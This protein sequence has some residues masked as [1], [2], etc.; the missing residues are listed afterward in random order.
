MDAEE[1]LGRGPRAAF[2]FLRRRGSGD[3]QQHAAGKVLCGRGYLWRL[4]DGEQLVFVHGELVA[5]GVIDGG[6]DFLEG[7]AVLAV[8]VV[9]GYVLYS[10]QKSTADQAA[11][12]IWQWQHYTGWRIARDYDSSFKAERG[13][14]TDH[15][16]GNECTDKGYPGYAAC[17]QQEYVVNGVQSAAPDDSHVA[18]S[19][20]LPPPGFSP[21]SAAPKTAAK[22][23][24]G[25][26]GVISD[27]YQHNVVLY[28]D[29]CKHASSVVIPATSV[30]KI[31]GRFNGLNKC[32]EVVDLVRVSFGGKSG[33][34]EANSLVE[35]VE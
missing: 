25:K 29:T 26:T 23:L 21:I 31:L 22:P 11:T 15:K 27:S 9:G 12:Q 20:P 5:W 24:R 34:I 19:S 14:W 33:W 17:P 10:N 3:A 13:I 2:R 28:V 18:S 8:V 32:Y 6:L 16:T 1:Q 35:N 4:E 7:G 30:V